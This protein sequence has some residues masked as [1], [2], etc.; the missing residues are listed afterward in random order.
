MPI[1]NWGTGLT[2]NLT[3]DT[4]HW[5]N[6]AA[7]NQAP[8]VPQ[9]GNYTLTYTDEVTPVS[10][11]SLSSRSSSEPQD[12]AY[13]IEESLKCLDQ[14]LGDL[15]DAKEVLS[16]QVEVLEESCTS[17]RNHISTLRMVANLMRTS[18]RKKP[19][20]YQSVLDPVP[21]EVDHQTQQADLGIEVEEQ[22]TEL[23]P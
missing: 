17:I 22:P 12:P 6:A 21:D 13:Q 14:E 19:R 8:P 15:E 11:A 5:N 1:N 20:R 10:T 9:G 23:E 16:T 18:S 3:F 2:G 7:P 4:S